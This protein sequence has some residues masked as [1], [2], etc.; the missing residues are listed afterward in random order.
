MT[1][2]ISE[3]DWKLYR[4][5]YPVARDRFYVLVLSEVSAITADSGASN[6]YRYQE[7]RRLIDRR[8]EELDELFGRLRRSSALLQLARWRSLGLVTDSE[9]AQ[10]GPETRNAVEMFLAVWTALWGICRGGRS[11][12][13]TYNYANLTKREWFATDAL[14]GSAKLSGLGLNL[15]ARAFNL[16]LVQGYAPT[17][18]ADPIRPGRWAGDAVAIIGDTD[19]N[20]L[21]YNDEFADL[22]A[23]V[24]LLVF[25]CDGFER[26]ASVAEEDSHLFIQI[27]HLVV[28]RQAPDLE[29]HVK[30]WLGTSI[31][32]RYKDLLPRRSFVQAEGDVARP[33]GRDKW[34]KLSRPDLGPH[35]AN[36][37]SR[38]RRPRS[39]FA[40]RGHLTRAPVVAK[41]DSSSPDATSS[42][43]C[44]QFV[45]SLR[46][47]NAVCD[48]SASRTVLRGA[49]L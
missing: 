21:R 48:A 26:I 25:S 45:P 16:L 6:I 34:R 27:C 24:I 18:A 30:Q 47:E 8:D 41:K 5:L 44:P 28:T 10:F 31:R 36:R 17:A 19:D 46:V 9:L 35:S 43:L 14:G 23:D 13:T 20:W 39:M 33:A 42:R 2:T 49:R 3:P 32:Q 22:A 11:M 4:P 1:V 12:G 40:P 38:S 37:N 15:T 7:I 29:P